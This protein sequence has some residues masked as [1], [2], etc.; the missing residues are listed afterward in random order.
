M[1]VQKQ[2][3][4]SY[5]NG[6][7]D[8]TPERWEQIY[9]IFNVTEDYFVSQ[10]HL[11]YNS[12]PDVIEELKATNDFLKKQ[13]ETLNA[14][15]QTIQEEKKRTMDLLEL[16]LKGNFPEGNT[17]EVSRGGAENVLQHGS[18]TLKIAS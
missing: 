6:R 11:K 3:I 10:N 16:A 2:T 13:L 1:G 17:L 12:N 8:P 15:L 18:V 9:N 5:E 14:H 7:I 4:W